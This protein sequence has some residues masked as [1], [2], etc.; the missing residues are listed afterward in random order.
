MNINHIVGA[1]MKHVERWAEALITN[2]EIDVNEFMR[3]SNQLI[4]ESLLSGRTDELYD[5]LRAFHRGILRARLTNLYGHSL[6]S[7]EYYY[8]NEIISMLKDLLKSKYA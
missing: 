4:N 8:T 1:V 7:D 2:K 5:R 3:Q 6:K